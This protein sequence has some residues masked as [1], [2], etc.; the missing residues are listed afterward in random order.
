MHP[1]ANSQYPVL[2]IPNLHVQKKKKKKNNHASKRSKFKSTLLTVN[3]QSPF[4]LES[5]ISYN[6]IL[7]PADQI[8]SIVLHSRHVTQH[9]SRDVRTICK[10]RRTQNL[11]SRLTCLA[12]TAIRRGRHRLKK[13]F[14]SH[15]W[16]Y[17]WPGGFPS[18]RWSQL[19]AGNPNWRIQS[20]R[21]LTPTSAL[22][23]S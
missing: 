7:C 1:V 4:I 19:L 16:P 2:L 10:L 22:L 20:R 3:K 23:C 18:T 12:D 5:A 21:F 15:F 11:S 17:V 9:A 8:L 13:M 6:W 14:Y